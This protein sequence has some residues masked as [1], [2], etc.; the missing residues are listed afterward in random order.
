MKEVC[1]W[2]NDRYIQCTCIIGVEEDVTGNKREE[3]REVAKAS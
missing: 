1:I 2:V 3:R